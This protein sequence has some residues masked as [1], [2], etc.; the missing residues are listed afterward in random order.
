MELFIGVSGRFIIHRDLLI[1]LII[2]AV[3]TYTM[4]DLCC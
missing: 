4:N 3:V 2:V 1:L